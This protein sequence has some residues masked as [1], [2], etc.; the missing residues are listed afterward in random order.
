MHDLSIEEK[1]I[2]CSV[3]HITQT[4]RILTSDILQLE[5]SSINC[6]NY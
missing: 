5:Y 6:N 1:S 2:V 4:T 3:E